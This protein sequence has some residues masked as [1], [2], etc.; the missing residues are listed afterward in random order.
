MDK[1]NRPALGFLLLGIAAIGRALLGVQ[2]TSS[3]AE[4]TLTVLA[5]LG[6]ALLAARCRKALP[7]YIGQ[8]VMEVLLCGLEVG[9]WLRPVLRAVDLWLVLAGVFVTLTAAEQ[10]RND[11]AY[12]AKHRLLRPVLDGASGR[13]D[14][15]ALCPD[16]PARRDPPGG[17]GGRCVCAVLPGTYLVR[18]PDAQHLQRPAGEENKADPVTVTQ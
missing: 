2:D 17:G 1:N 12:T 7:A 3:T 14:G 6:A 9:G 10:V 13:P 18:H 4:V 8:L 11:E 5:G 16:R 15:T